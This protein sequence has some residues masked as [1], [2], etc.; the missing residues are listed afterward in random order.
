MKKAMFNQENVGG[1]SDAT[2]QRE[3]VIVLTNF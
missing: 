1:Y 3:R 2:D